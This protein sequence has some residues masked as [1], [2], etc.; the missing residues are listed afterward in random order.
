MQEYKE[1]INDMEKDLNVWK[2]N[3][4]NSIINDLDALKENINFENNDNISNMLNMIE[5]LRE[6]INQKHNDLASSFEDKISDVESSIMAFDD[7]LKDIEY[8]Q[9]SI[10]ENIEKYSNKLDNVLKEYEER[11]KSKII[12]IEDS[13]KQENDKAMNYVN[14]VKNNDDFSNVEIRLSDLE[15][16]I[17][18]L[19]N[20][21]LEL[22]KELAKDKNELI[23][24]I[25]Q[26]KKDMYSKIEKDFEGL[27]NNVPN[28]EEL[29]DLF[30]SE[31]EGLI[32]EFEEFKK[33]ILEYH[34]ENN[35]FAQIFEEEKTRLI[36]Y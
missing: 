21:N 4:L 14:I 31:K 25:Y 28:M 8:N 29:T 22:S 7:R 35:N 11:I 30:V 33:E 9:S 18:R 34:I 19:D 20:S 32:N 16:Y 2:D 13:I 23:E 6:K 12:N 27:K 26:L 36:R 5:E 24:T 10:N 3:N 1:K 15:N 17:N